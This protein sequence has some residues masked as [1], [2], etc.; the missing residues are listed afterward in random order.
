MGVCGAE[1][2]S[3]NI[4]IFNNEKRV[5]RIARGSGQHPNHVLELVAEYQKMSKIW[6]NMKGMKMPA[7]GRM[8]MNTQNM[9]A[10]HLSKAL[11]PQMLQQMGGLGGLQNM[12]KQMNTPEMQKMMAKM[13]AGGMGGMGGLEALAGLK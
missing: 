13:G 10:A 5:L 3:T 8:S 6:G 11:P 2:D 7:K 1:L 4:K 12:L 9:N